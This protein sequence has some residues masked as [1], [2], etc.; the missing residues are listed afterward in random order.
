MDEEKGVKKGQFVLAKH[1]GEGPYQGKIVGK[2][3]GKLSV[4]LFSYLTG[5][6]NAIKTFD[7][8]NLSEVQIFNTAKQWRD[9]AAKATA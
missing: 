9:A 3:N 5:E 2:S 4:Q 7:I 6:P 8:S 1:D